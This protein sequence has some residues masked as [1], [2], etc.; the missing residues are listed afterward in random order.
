MK[1]KCTLLACCFEENPPN[2]LKRSPKREGG[3]GGRG[4]GHKITTL[5]VYALSISEQLA[6]ETR[7]YVPCHSGGYTNQIEP[8]TT[9]GV[10][11][12]KHVTLMLQKPLD[13]DTHH[14]VMMT[15]N[16]G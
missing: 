5:H 4:E 15:R 6:S 13:V 10:G 9:N 3:G 7:E 14:V 12:R 11:D 1:G 16:I 8:D 2:K